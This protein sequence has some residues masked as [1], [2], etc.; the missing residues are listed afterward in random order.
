MGNSYGRQGQ[1]TE[2]APAPGRGATESARIPLRLSGFTGEWSAQIQPEQITIGHIH[3]SFYTVITY[4]E[5]IQIWN[6]LT[7]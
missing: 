5:V 2:V 4:Y 1:R 3:K 7:I 6:I